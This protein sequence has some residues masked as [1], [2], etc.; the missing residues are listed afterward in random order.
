MKRGH[1]LVLALLCLIV[2][3]GGC[4]GQLKQHKLVGSWELQQPGKVMN[5]VQSGDEGAFEETSTDSRMSLVFESSGRF[6]TVTRMGSI[7]QTKEGTYEIVED[8]SNQEFVKVSCSIQMQI[9][10]HEIEF[11]DENTIKLVP[12]NM[13]GLSMKLQFERK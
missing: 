1:F 4:G 12:P 9:T 8:V 13:A 11:I 7:D 5:R 10:E 3:V 2:L 6:R